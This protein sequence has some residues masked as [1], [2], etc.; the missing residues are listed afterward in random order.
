MSLATGGE[1]CAAIKTS[2]VVGL[3]G[4]MEARRFGAAAMRSD[5]SFDSPKLVT[6]NFDSN[7]FEGGIR[8]GLERFRLPNRR[9]LHRR[10]ARANDGSGLTPCS[11]RQPPLLICLVLIRSIAA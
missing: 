9:M 1:H 3:K 4:G 5:S 10:S 8:K 7:K 2:G 11:W 6:R